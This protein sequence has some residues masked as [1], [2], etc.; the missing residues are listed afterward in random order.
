M[1][2]LKCCATLTIDQGV[3]VLYS[4]PKIDLGCRHSIFDGHAEGCN[5]L[6]MPFSGSS[7]GQ[8]EVVD[9]VLAHADD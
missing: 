4:T 7:E 8:V 5:L 2:R 9:S 6:G 1:T 3:I